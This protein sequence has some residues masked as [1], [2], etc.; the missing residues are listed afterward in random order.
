MKLRLSLIL[1]F[2]LV[3]SL[4]FFNPVFAAGALKIPSDPGAWGFTSLNAAQNLV[5]FKD[6]GGVVKFQVVNK[7]GDVGS[8]DQGKAVTIR[9]KSG[10]IIGKSAVGDN[11]VISI[12]EESLRG[13]GFTVDVVE[14]FGAD[15]GKN[16]P[17][18]TSNIGQAITPNTNA[19]V[20]NGNGAS[21]GSGGGG[22]GSGSG[23]GSGLVPCDGV[24]CSIQKILTMGVKIYNY[25]TGFG[26]I[27]AV[28][29]MVWGGF[30]YITAQGDS[31]K[32][33]AAK[34]IVI[35]AIKGIVV[36]AVS[37][38]IVNTV[39]NWVSSGKGLDAGKNIQ[40]VEDVSE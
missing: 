18:D 11:G 7:T 38:L 5:A 3:V 15:I 22:G 10:N 26:A 35:N 8:I 25:L 28:G 30:S 37:A 29:A 1:L 31:S 13:D 12:K 9:D 19:S 23:S 40:K 16:I 36:L 34:E 17:I 24:D 20:S 39:I 27:L 2:C 21:G 4:A 14:P 6:L 32:M 33:S